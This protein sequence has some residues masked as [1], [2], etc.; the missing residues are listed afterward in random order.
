VRITGGKARGIRLVAPS[1][2]HTRPAT[3]RLR[4]SAFSSIG[5]QIEKCK[6]ADLFAGTGSYGLE[7]LSRGA[8]HISFYENNRQALISLRENIANVCKSC[9]E[10]ASVS[11][12]THSTDLFS[13]EKNLVNFDYIFV[14]PPYKTIPQNLKKLFNLLTEKMTS[15]DTIIVFEL[16]GNIE[17]EIDN[18]ELFKRLGKAG[19]DKPTIAFFRRLKK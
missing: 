15:A 9:S 12:T 4:E 11:T 5:P 19:R 7:A 8:T 17:P 18:W 1:S 10:E 14:D 6:V 13:T 3:D 2:D 16:P